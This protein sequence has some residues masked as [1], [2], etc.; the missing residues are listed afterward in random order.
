MRE[1]SAETHQTL[2]YFCERLI[3]EIR[4]GSGDGVLSFSRLTS[5]AGDGGRKMR[6]SAAGDGGFRSELSHR[7]L[8]LIGF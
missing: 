4:K 7:L 6:Q 5:A 2:T 8:P 1:P 3:L